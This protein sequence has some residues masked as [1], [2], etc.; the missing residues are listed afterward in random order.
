MG[1][2]PPLPSLV[3][4]DPTQG[5]SQGEPGSQKRHE[6]KED[7][8]GKRK[9]RAATEF[10]KP[11]SVPDYYG[12]DTV[13]SVYGH[14]AKTTNALKLHIM[15][16][17]K[18]EYLYECEICKKGFIQKDGYNTH[19]FIHAPDDKKIPCTQ[20]D[21]DIRFVSQRTMKAYIKSQHQE[22]RFFVCTHCTTTYS[23]KGILSEH[24]NGYKKNPNRVPLYCE[25]CPQGK[26]P[27][28]HLPKRVMEHKRNVH[29]WQ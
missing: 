18:G 15:K 5:T 6:G 9:R 19:K 2:L 10:D 27:T 7:A 4:A 23:T 21:C 28:F 22:R 20:K 14:V 26:S 29:G 16:S 25:L 12:G 24:I 11:T 3:Q 13:C 17:H 8:P 1:K